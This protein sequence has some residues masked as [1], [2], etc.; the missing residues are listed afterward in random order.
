MKAT[1]AGKK[2]NTER[3]IRLSLVLFSAIMAFC[4]VM[5]AY[6]KVEW[7]TWLL[8]DSITVSEGFTAS[9]AYSRMDVKIVVQVHDSTRDTLRLYTAYGD[10]INRVSTQF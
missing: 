6:V 4:L 5:V 8:N 9:L 7:E 1:A 10:A 3:V 2:A